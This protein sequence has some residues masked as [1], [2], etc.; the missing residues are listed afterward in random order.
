MER[1]LKRLRPNDTFQIVRFSNNASQLGPAPLLATAE[2]VQ[3]GLDYVRS[4]NGNGGTM[5]IEGIKAALDF[6]HD[7]E[8][9]RLVSFMTDGYI[10]NEAQIFGEIYQRLGDARI[11][12]FGVGSS[13]NRHL[14]EGMARL[15]HGAVAYVGLDDSAGEAVDLFYKRISHPAMTDIEI[16]WGGMQVSDVYPREIPDLFVGRPVVLT[17]RF[18]GDG[19]A[20]IRV[21][22]R[23]GARE[24]E[25]AL[26][27]DLEDESA[28]HAGI[29]SVWARTLIRHLAD[30]M[31]YSDDFELPLQIREVA[32]EYNL[33]SKYT[34][35]VAV[36]SKTITAGDHGISLAVP[37]PV[38]V[39]V[40]Y[41]TTVSE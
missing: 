32:F 14:L 36:D 33:M 35:F 3:R 11:F 2:N 12:S 6:P 34:S 26:T 10:G 40:R 24:R 41:D 15:G 30:R 22:G 37:V 5:M 16:D 39:G 20:D 19:L 21:T 29:P 8:R 7:R 28:T 4:L 9:L 18:E 13:V 17:G 25:I 31:T 27:A 38:P 1:A 23:C